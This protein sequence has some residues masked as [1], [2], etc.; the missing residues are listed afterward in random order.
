MFGDC[1]NCNLD[2]R[3]TCCQHILLFIT[4]FNTVIVILDIVIKNTLLL[5]RYCI[6]HLVVIPTDSLNHPI[7]P[8][9]K[10]KVYNSKSYQSIL[11]I[12]LTAPMVNLASFY[13]EIREK[14]NEK[15]GIPVHSKIAPVVPIRA[16]YLYDAVLIYGNFNESGSRSLFEED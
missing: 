9:S 5:S 1:E 14:A 2:E 10:D 16:V 4:L 8:K 3:V 15:F 12:T 6:F 13:R 11:Q 7:F